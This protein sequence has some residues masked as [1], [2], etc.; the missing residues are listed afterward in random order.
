MNQVF[1]W[2]LLFRDLCLI[3]TMFSGC[4]KKQQYFRGMFAETSAMHSD[5]EASDSGETSPC[6]KAVAVK[7][8][9]TVKTEKNINWLQDSVHRQGRGKCTEQ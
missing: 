1:K 3:L 9:K 2:C 8:K 7:A 6:V 4:C 5:N